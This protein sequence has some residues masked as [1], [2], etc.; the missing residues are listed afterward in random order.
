MTIEQY[1]MKVLSVSKIGKKFST[2]P[3]ALENYEEL[4]K[5]TLKM[6][7]QNFTEKVD[8][9]LFTRDLYPTPNSSIRVIILNELNEILFCKEADD[10]KWSV[11]GGWAE[12]FM[13]L[14]DNAIKEV[15][16]EI[17]IDISIE[18]P[19][20]TFM[21]EKYR[22]PKVAISEYVT[23]FLAR[24]ESKTPLNIGFEVLDAK[25]YRLDDHP[26]LSSKTTITEISTAYGIA[27]NNGDM[28]VD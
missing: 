13:S 20:A 1:L 5:L 28:Y 11:P 10:Q 26:E 15:R 24:I 22:Q 2:D 3:Y 17:G 16:E 4:E 6:L 25:F 12:I 27:I 19:L 23:Y 7:N 9:N 18:R 21:R 14:S 8:E